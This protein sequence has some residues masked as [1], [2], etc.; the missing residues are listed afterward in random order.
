MMM[1]VFKQDHDQLE[2]IEM[3][4]HL[5]DVLIAITN[6]HQFTPHCLQHGPEAVMV[7]RTTNS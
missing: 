2:F 7:N 5:T 1:R 3:S 6:K 4:I